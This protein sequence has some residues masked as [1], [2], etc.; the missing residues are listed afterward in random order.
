[1]E[2]GPC[3]S[4]WPV[5]LGQSNYAPSR[6]SSVVKLSTSSFFLLS[7][8]CSAPVEDSESLKGDGATKWKELEFLSDCME[9]SCTH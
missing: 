1:M 7:G 3:D 5:E 2:V 9:Q 4:F 6:L 8:V